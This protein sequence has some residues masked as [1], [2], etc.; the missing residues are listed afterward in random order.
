MRDCRSI[1]LCNSNYKIVSKLLVNCLKPFLPLLVSEEQGA[2][3]TS[4]SIYENIMIASKIFHSMHKRSKGSNL[5]AIKVDMERAY[6]T[7]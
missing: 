3:L 6:D 4:R 1:S 2:F 5:M 7:I